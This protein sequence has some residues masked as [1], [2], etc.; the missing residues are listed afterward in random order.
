V[1]DYNRKIRGADAMRFSEQLQEV[2]L[3][4]KAEWR[5]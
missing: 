4:Q 1:I 5:C 3:K 2:T